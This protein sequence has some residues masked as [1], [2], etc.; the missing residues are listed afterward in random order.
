M[1]SERTMSQRRRDEGSV[2][3]MVLVL[4][5]VGALVV[6]PMLDYT[7][8][9]FRSNRV[10]TDR[11]ANTEAAK[12]GLRMAL[13]DP[14]NV[15]LTCDGGGN[16][17]PADSTINGVSVQTT[18]TEVSEVGPAA[19]LGYAVPKGAVATQLGADLPASFSGTTASSGP[20]Y[21][22]PADPDWWASPA[23][24]DPGAQYSATAT[25][26]LIWMPELP[27]IPSTHRDPDPYDMP[28]AFDCQ[29]FFP[30]H[31]TQPVDLS[32]NI[33]FTSGVYYF[34]EPVT[35][36]DDADV[37]V[38]YGLE[39]FSPASDCADDLQVA[40]NVI[41]PPSTYDISG[42]GATWVFGADARLIIDNSAMG[43]GAR[44]RFN[45][46]YDTADRGGRIS[47]M[48]VNG[49]DA[50]SGD[51]DVAKVNRIPRSLML[52]D[53]YEVPVDGTGY[54]VSSSTFTDK[55]RLPEEPAN[56]EDDEFRTTDPAPNG[57][58]VLT[59]DEVTGQAAGGALLGEQ[60]ATGA[61]VTSPYDVQIRERSTTTW[62]D[63]CPANDL[64]ITPPATVGD[65]NVISCVITGLDANRDY[66]V[67]I[68]TV[69]EVGTSPWEQEDV[70]SL[71]GSPIIAAP[72]SVTNVAAVDGAVDDV[73]QVSWD[74][75]ASD[76]GAPITGYTATAY[77]VALVPHANVAP[78][79]A[80]IGSETVDIGVPLIF[81]GPRSVVG[82]VRA[83]DPN[84][85]DL[86]LTIDTS[87]LPPELTAVA[88]DADD[89]I[90]VTLNGLLLA[91]SYSIPYVVTDPSG[92]T[93]AGE[94][95][96]EIV[97]LTALTLHDP[98]AESVQLLADV[99]V[100]IVSRLPVGDSDGMPLAAVPITVDTTGL[101]ADW[102]V[103]VSGL[104]VS[105]TTVAP[106]GVY[107]IPYSVT[108]SSG[109][110]TDSTI[111]V[112]VARDVQPVASCTVTSDPGVVMANV[113]EMS[114]PDLTPGTPTSGN[115]GYLFD[116]VATNAAGSSA[117]GLSTAPLPLGFDGTGIG[118]LPPPPRLVT[119]WVPEPIIDID[120][121]GAAPVELAVAGYVAVP[122]GRVAVE[123]P[124]GF[125]IRVNGGVMAGTFA[126]NDARDTGTA[127]SLPIGF[128]ND[129]V[130]QRKVRIVSVAGNITS[131]AIVELNEDGAGYAVNTWVVG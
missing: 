86:T 116:V 69:N 2:L 70:R 68:R 16:L 85:D 67:R 113:C 23:A 19:A 8:A 108:D 56:V 122:M 88:N 105:I 11:T 31:Y 50:T 77:Q 20:A 98:D 5:V 107:T 114:L 28:A 1:M 43:S 130:L 84:G 94:L 29:V 13:G 92:E 89:T 104:D 123:N 101:D 73:A 93:A 12:G 82:H 27:R 81:T 102:N 58:V 83:F 26:D 66:D 65:P 30:G 7:I 64:M 9:V 115:V 75:P 100:P 129:I 112:T 119:P 6:V 91:G 37:V 128:K 72:S 90:E 18:C 33:Y 36:A 46:R 74:A 99:G 35:V 17:T 121:S 54:Q 62:Y 15:F 110:S 10:V 41:D 96:V 32:G 34:E 124:N 78:V 106:D 79:A 61:W 49:D 125:D 80:P 45:Q 97:A 109:A 127:G 22:Y 55:A 120:V 39:D 40:S 131:T 60:D 48:T 57:G 38:G 44:I 53:I 21:P 52:N 118:L 71:P 63:T 76:G 4:M 24:P 14:K 87:S 59:W 47:I 117:L 42:G 3:P 51:H 103:S 25:E 126:I 111:E 95:T